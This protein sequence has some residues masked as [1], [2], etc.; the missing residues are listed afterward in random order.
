MTVFAN[1]GNGDCIPYDYKGGLIEQNP[2]ASY[3]KVDHSLVIVGYGVD[4]ATGKNYLIIRNSWG[5]YWGINGYGKLAFGDCAS[6]L[7]SSGM[8]RPHFLPEEWTCGEE[9]ERGICNCECGAYDPECDS[10]YDSSAFTFR[11][12]NDTCGENKIC[13][14]EGKCVSKNNNKYK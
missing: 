5:P 2:S 11:R 10:Y 8:T 13:S 3:T 1:S 4:E 12:H 9:N 14:P 7:E 6:L